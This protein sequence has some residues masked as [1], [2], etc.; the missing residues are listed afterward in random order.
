M[1]ESIRLPD[2]SLTYDPQDQSRLRRDLEVAILRLSERVEENKVNPRVFDVLISFDQA[3][4]PYVTIKCNPDTLSF[5]FAVSTIAPPDIETVRAEPVR[6]SSRGEFDINTI[7]QPG[8]ILFVAVLPYSGVDADGTEGPVYFESATYGVGAGNECRAVVLAIDDTTMTVRV[9]A[10]AAVIGRAGVTLETLTG[11][12]L[13]SG[14]P[15]MVSGL[16]PQTYIFARPAS[17]AGDGLARFSATFPEAVQDFDRITIPEIGKNPLFLGCRANVL[18][19]G[20]RNAT[21]RV[22]VADPIPQGADS[23]EL[24]Y[25][26]SVGSPTPASPQTVTPQNTYSGAAGT[27]RDITV[28]RVTAGPVRLTVTASSLVAPRIED[29]DEIDIPAREGIPASL[30]VESVFTE[31][32]CTISFQAGDTDLLELSI[33]N[34]AFSA[35][36]ASP[37]VVTREPASGGQDRQYT[38]RSTGELGD[39]KTETVRVVRR[40]V[41][42]PGTPTITS[43]SLI[44]GVFGCDGSGD[45]DVD[46]SVADMPGGVTYRVVWEILQGFLLGPTGGTINPATAPQNIVTDLCDAVDTPRARVTVTAF[47][48]ST[49]IAARTVESD[50]GT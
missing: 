37:I 42:V 19:L 6:T 41:I 47:D 12:S 29:G 10:Q 35:A 44:N 26:L 43:V 22:A 28:E 9:T 38:F 39:V 1:S 24:D 23:V 46:W 33:D 49:P 21:V 48:G 45:F 17:G 7:L 40:D 31:D 20:A 8:E 36:P 18:T 32:D 15:V 2:P 14:L 34:G 4:Y 30:A 5:K 16:S 13:L 3:G 25:T 27:F 50:I 11:A